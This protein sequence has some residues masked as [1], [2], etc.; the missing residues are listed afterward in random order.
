[1]RIILKIART[2]LLCVVALIGSAETPIPDPAARALQATLQ[3]W[4][5]KSIGPIQLYKG[6]IP[7]S[8]PSE[9]RETHKQWLDM[10]LIGQV[11]H[12]VYTAYLPPSSWASGAAVLIFPGGG[13]VDLG[14]DMEGHWIAAGLQDCGIAAFLVSAAQ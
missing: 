9:N 13:Y 2:I 12:P 1:M 11:S 6:D 5:T 14:W 8:K 10:E 4:S 3:T 7:N